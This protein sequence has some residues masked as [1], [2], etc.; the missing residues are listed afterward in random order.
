MKAFNRIRNSL[1][2]KKRKML[3]LGIYILSLFNPLFGL[4]DSKKDS[5]EEDVQS[6]ISKTFKQESWIDLN[7]NSEEVVPKTNKIVIGTGSNRIILAETRGGE[8]LP[9]TGKFNPGAKAKAAA[10]KQ[11]AQR[12]WPTKKK[13]SS[14]SGL[15]AEGFTPQGGFSSRPGQDWRNPYGAGGPKSVTH[16]GKSNGSE[17]KGQ[18]QGERIVRTI[19]DYEGYAAKLTKKSLSHGT[20]KH[21]HQAGV[22]DPLPQDPKQ[23][24]TKFSPIRTRVN[25][26]NNALVG[27]RLENAMQDRETEIYKNFKFKDLPARCYHSEK[28]KLVI[29][30]PQE[31]PLKDTV[32]RFHKPSVKQVTRIQTENRL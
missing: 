2:K 32:I 12:G 17:L 16:L 26:L 15:F 30:I 28:Y 29:I 5:I 10:K 1:K 20:S 27:D 18:T 8:N 21:G 19:I 23:K 7:D 9:G 3:L 13:S 24:P 11:V 31:G 4:I 22:N 25:D 6:E 14:S